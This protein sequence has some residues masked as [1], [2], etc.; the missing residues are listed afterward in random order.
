MADV[1]ILILG[2]T[3]EARSLAAELVDRGQQVVTSLAGRVS[4]PVLPVGEVRSGGFGGVRGLLDYLVGQR[5]SVV[6]D[7]THP[8]ATGITGNA[9]VACPMAGVRLLRLARPGWEQHPLADTFCWVGGMDHARDAAERFG[10]RPFL[11]TGR[12]SL[13]VFSGW[14]DR[15]VLARVVDPPEWVVPRTWE[16][17]RSRGPYGYA[18]ERALMADRRVDVVVTKDSGGALTEAKLRA[19]HDLA[20][21]VVVVRRPKA[22]DGVEVVDSVAATVARLGQ[23]A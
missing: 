11:T 6:V 23:L 18:A 1:R 19:A 4:D 2:G 10:T 5:V 22:P 21:P 12:Q 8:F 14:D 16:V 15:Y 7:A 13:E 3:G 9:V 17:L 20:V